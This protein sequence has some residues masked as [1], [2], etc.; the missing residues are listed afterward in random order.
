MKGNSE[1]DVLKVKELCIEEAVKRFSRPMSE[2]GGQIWNEIR[3]P[4]A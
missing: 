2:Y 3:S 4:D 1:G